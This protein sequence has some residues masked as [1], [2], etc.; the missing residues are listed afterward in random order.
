M[1]IGD[2]SRSTLHTPETSSTIS[3]EFGWGGIPRERENQALILVLA[4]RAWSSAIK[5]LKVLAACD[6][7]AHIDSIHTNNPDRLNFSARARGEFYADW[8]R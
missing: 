3:T 8:E 6:S 2:S 5:G 7:Q 1:C 4:A